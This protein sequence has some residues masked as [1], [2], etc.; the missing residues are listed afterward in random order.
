MKTK[1]LNQIIRNYI[2][3]AIDLDGYDQYK[4]VQLNEH[5][6]LQAVYTIFKS[7]YCYPQNLQR[8]GSEQNVFAQ[9]LMGLPSCINIAFEN[10]RILEL[11]REWGFLSQV[12]SETVNNSYK[13]TLERKE[14]KFISEWFARI[15]MAFFSNLKRKGVTKPVRK[16]VD[17]YQVMG[18]YGQGWECVTSEETRKEAR[19]RLKEYIENESGTAFKIVKKR[20]K[21][22]SINL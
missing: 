1:E 18:N 10:Y 14:D 11:G 4:G 2:L 6:R 3:S 12:E 9:W 17:E 19:E 8:Y 22:E 13:K 16:T 15:A 7:E 20:V 5:D 21:L